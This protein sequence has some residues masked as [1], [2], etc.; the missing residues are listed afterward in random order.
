M[1]SLVWVALNF[2]RGKKYGE[3]LIATALSQFNG[4]NEVSIPVSKKSYKDAEKEIKTAEQKGIKI[5]TINSKEYPEQLRNIEDPPIAIYMQGNI[6]KSDKNAIS[7][8]GSR[9][10]SAYGRVVA[11]TF[12]KKLA[13]VG[14]TIVSG[15]A[16][17]IDTISHKGALSVKGRTIA[18]MG[19]GLDYIYPSS[20]KDLAERIIKNGAVISEFPLGTAPLRYNFPFRNRIISGLSIGTLV[21]EAAEHSGSLIT[22]RLAAEQ[23]KDV[24]VVPGDITSDK[25]K[26]ANQLIKDGAIPVTSVMD[27]LQYIGQAYQV[28]FEEENKLSDEEKLI[29]SILNNGA[30]TIEFISKETGIT[31]DKLFSLLTYMEVKG[32]VKRTAGRFIKS[33]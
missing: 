30:K 23:G 24:F 32:L 14:L 20:N 4:G 7:I 29:L 5:V 22:A 18:V 3:E 2:L 13:S 11:E 21:V 6:I 25:S 8:V 19:S 10:C 1:N 17:G 15:L 12:S 9:K 33:L 16:V 26:G 28:N 27:I 31:P